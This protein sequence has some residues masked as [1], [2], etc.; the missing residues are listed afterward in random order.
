MTEILNGQTPE[1]V[2]ARLRAAI[3]KGQAWYPALL[4][5]VAVWPLDSEEYDGRHYQYLIGGEALDLILLFE[6][7]SREL[8]DLIPAQERD[9]LLFKGIAPQELTADELLAFLGE[10]RYRQYLNYFYGITVEEALLVVTQSDVRKEHRSLGVRR[11]G[12]VIDEAFVQLYERTHDEML[13]QFRREKRY[14]KTGTIKIHQLKEFTYWL[15]KYR[16]LHSEK[17]RVASDTNKSLNYLK[18]YA[19]R[20]QQKSN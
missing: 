16:L 15:F 11:E 14:S 1:L 2:I 9:N 18:K 7:F 13:D 6:R 12:T 20:L 4:E 5:A 3:E 8:E 17:A 19:R 10:V